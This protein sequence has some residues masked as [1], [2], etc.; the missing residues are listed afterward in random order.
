MEDLE[1]LFGMERHRF[2]KNLPSV[3]DGRKILY[4]PFAL[5]EI[6]D[7]LLKETSTQRKR[8]TRG[9]SEKKV[10]LSNP[11]VK[12]RV[13]MGIG[14]RALALSRYREILARFMTVVSDHLASGDS[15]EP[16]PKDVEGALRAH[17][18]SIQSSSVA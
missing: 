6:M 4:G 11:D 1:I 8:G 16:L 12:K 14:W 15:K 13:L 10:W 17:I 7:A 18:G 5:V 3:R 2:P 9:G